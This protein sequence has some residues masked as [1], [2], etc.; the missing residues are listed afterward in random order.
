MHKGLYT[1]V[2]LL[3]LKKALDTVDP[4]FLI[5]KLENLGIRGTEYL[6]GLKVT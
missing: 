1:G 5:Q 6:V 3:D 4:H 2:V